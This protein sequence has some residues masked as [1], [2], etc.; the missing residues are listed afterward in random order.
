MS[1]KSLRNCQ[2]GSHRDSKC[3]KWPHG[4]GNKLLLTAPGILPG[5]KAVRA[6]RWPPTPILRRGSEC[7]RHLYSPLDVFTAG[8]ELTF[9]VPTTKPR[10]S[11]RGRGGQTTHQMPGDADLLTTKHNSTRVICSNPRSTQHPSQRYTLARRPRDSRL[12]KV[13]TGCSITQR[14]SNDDRTM[15]TAINCVPNHKLS[16]QYGR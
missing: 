3:L 15:P 6:C 12:W 1:E 16:V 8:Y 14:T 9:T 10:H 4:H 5:G 13:N 2:T 7:A 11:V